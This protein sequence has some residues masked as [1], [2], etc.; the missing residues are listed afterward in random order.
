[1][2]VR[3]AIGILLLLPGLC[4]GASVDMPEWNEAGEAEEYRLGGGLW[5]SGLLP[6][7][8]E[9][10]AG[11]EG[12]VNGDLTFIGPEDS[13]AAG[14]GD[15]YES[16]AGSGAGA[17]PGLADDTV[18]EA[19]PDAIAEAVP[20][21]EAV[22]SLPPIEG[23]LRN[24]YFEVAPSDFLVDPQRLLTEQ[25]SNDLRRFLQYHSEESKFHI[26]VMVFGQNQE[27]P[28]DIDLESLHGE[29]FG[30]N[31]AVLMSYHYEDP[32]NFALVYNASVREIFEPEVFE[33]IRQNCLREGTS[34]ENAPDQV[35]EMAVELSLQL[36]WM[37][38]LLE[39]QLSES[40]EHEPGTAVALATKS[41]VDVPEL[42]R[43]DAPDLF[44]TTSGMSKEEWLSLASRWGIVLGVLL[45]A[46]LAMALITRLAAWWSQREATVGKPLVF[47]DIEI[48]PRLGGEFSGGAFVSM[49]FDI[50]EGGATAGG[51]SQLGL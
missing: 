32:E 26:Y 45:A 41:G 15:P 30:E 19:G 38:R 27:I 47:P 23:E 8:A 24:W 51:R 39:R 43:E 42:L 10:D 25:K 35:E 3:L 5:P 33:R 40:G 18:P 14:D 7:G 13:V 12:S 49:S 34:T 28:D 20:D 11:S 29:W 44:A 22:E 37:T 2:K 16:T 1:M 21:A 46:F 31:P 48:P 6:E 17:I 36:Y 9:E 50:S 4:L